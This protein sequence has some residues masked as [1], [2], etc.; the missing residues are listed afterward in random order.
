MAF[1]QAFGAPTRSGGMLT[2]SGRSDP[3]P[4][5]DILGIR[6]FLIQGERTVPASVDNPDAS[7]HV[8]V[9]SD[10][11]AAGAAVAVG[12]ETRRVNCTTISWAQPVEIPP[13]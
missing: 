8:D 3:D 13:P 9:P 4:P 1:K 6:V 10:G 7:W 12:I 2:L 5:G 11:F